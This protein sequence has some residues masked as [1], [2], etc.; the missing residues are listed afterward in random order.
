MPDDAPIRRTRRRFLLRTGAA[1]SLAAFAASGHRRVL[2]ESRTPAMPGVRVL[3]ERETPFGRLQAIEIGR[4]RYLAYGPA[5]RFVYQSAFDLDRPDELVAP[6]TR[7]MMLGVVYADPCRRVAQIGVGAG[8]MAR[9]A[10]R[11]F[12]SVDVHAVDIDRNAL[13]LGA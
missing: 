12:T 4:K 11:T 10:V 8:S 9:Y 3:E 2:A 1:L 7:L 6:Y 5:L 13:E